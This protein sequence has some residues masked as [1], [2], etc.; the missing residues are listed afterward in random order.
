MYLEMVLIGLNFINMNKPI[1]KY[2]KYI[3]Y[4]EE[5]IAKASNTES[6]AAYVVSLHM[7]KQLYDGIE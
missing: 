7:F 5:R 4:L 2:S 3:I 1:S 6:K